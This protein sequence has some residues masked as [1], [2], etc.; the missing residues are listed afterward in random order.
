[1]PSF[2]ASC[3]G[4]TFDNDKGWK[5]ARCDGVKMQSLLFQSLLNSVQKL[6]NYHAP[7]FSVAAWRPTRRIFGRPLFDAV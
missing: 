1:M 5:V 4:R 3:D 2:A 7:S 6:C